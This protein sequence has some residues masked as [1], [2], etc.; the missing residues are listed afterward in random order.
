MIAVIGIPRA[1]GLSDAI[2]EALRGLG[3]DCVQHDVDRMDEIADLP[4][5]R[6]MA[7]GLRGCVGRTFLYMADWPPRTTRFMLSGCRFE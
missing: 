2:A 6:V 5:G 4:G 1:A 3:H 7:G